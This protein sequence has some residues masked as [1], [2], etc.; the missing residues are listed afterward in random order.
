MRSK[1]FWRSERGVKKMRLCPSLLFNA[2]IFGQCCQV[3]I[4]NIKFY[5]SGFLKVVWHDNNVVWHVR[6][7]SSY[8]R[9]FSGVGSKKRLAFFKTCLLSV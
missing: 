5:K 9:P 8:F 6:H 4:C 2:D 7:D 3:G 1:T